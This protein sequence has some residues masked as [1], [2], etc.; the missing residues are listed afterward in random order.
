[1]D[2]SF[3][4]M[5]KII[6]FLGGFEAKVMPLGGHPLY[7][8]KIKMRG[9]AAIDP[10][11]VIKQAMPEFTHPYTSTGHTDGWLE[12]CFYLTADYWPY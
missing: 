5:Q 4:I 11:D 3:E 7:K 1:M 6:P 12:H 8:L 2:F 10:Q 9:N